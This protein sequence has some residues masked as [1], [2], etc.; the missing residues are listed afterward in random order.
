MA[1]TFEIV[2]RDATPAATPAAPAS[3][4]A[5]SASRR[6]KDTKT[7]S[8]DFGE[9]AAAQPVSQQPTA[10][11]QTRSGFTGRRV[12]SL[13]RVY[14]YFEGE[15]VAGPHAE[16]SHSSRSQKDSSREAQERHDARAAVR[17]IE[18]QAQEHLR[19]VAAISRESLKTDEDYYQQRQKDLKKAREADLLTER[20][21][22]AA[23]SKLFREHDPTKKREAAEQRQLDA[24]AERV[25]ETSKTREQRDAEYMARL[26]QAHSS[27]KLS[28]DEL[29]QATA[30]LHGSPWEHAQ[31]LITNTSHLAS[32]FGMGG[33]LGHVARAIS[34]GTATNNLWKQAF[35]SG[36]M[37][38]RFAAAGGAAG[39]PPIPPVSAVAGAAAGAEAAGG[40]IAAGGAG[41]GTAV[42]GAASGLGRIAAV[43]GPV[44]VALGALAAATYLGVSAVRSFARFVEGEVV[45]LREYS[46]DVAMAQ[47]TTDFRRE[48]RSLHAAERLGPT[49][50]KF[51][52]VRSRLEDSTA[53]AIDEFKLAFLRT[54]EP[55]LPLLESLAPLIERSA[56]S[57]VATY[58]AF[59]A[60]SNLMDGQ[61]MPA[62]K[63]FQH[64]MEEMRRALED[65]N[66]EDFDVDPF[67]V[68]WLGGMP[69]PKNAGAD[70]PGRAA[71]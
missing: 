57:T 33:P 51:E 29:K 11:Q 48:M 17:E 31:G 56:E 1:A 4:P 39:G 63:H 71:P 45:R 19:R 36:G 21:Y 3:S 10:A 28:D 26:R 5:A 61:F 62:W 70:I 59:R 54:L 13:G 66:K 34:I 7:G 68:Q 64:S 23:R 40:A 60:L 38:S 6:S 15:R 41:G 8:F 35:G 18:D 14:H 43:A 27:G 20:E 46:T 30:R 52:N 22:V 2:V 47:A 50:A 25:R 69:I 24:F 9:P 67:F 49:V 37:L 44:G 65:K 55:Y 32:A 58:H 53:R 42:A 16:R 12:D